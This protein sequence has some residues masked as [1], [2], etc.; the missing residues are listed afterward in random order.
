N[1]PVPDPKLPSGVVTFVLTDI[2][3]STRMLRRLE[4]RY[5]DVLERHI[6]L[7]REVWEEHGGAYVSATGDSCFGAFPDAAAALRA[8]GE[9]HRGLGQE[10][11]STD[12]GLRVRMGIHTGLAS[13]RRDGYVALAVHQ[14]ERVMA[15]AHGGQIL[16]SDVSARNVESLGGF[17]L[18]SAGRYRL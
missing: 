7:L 2:E 15:A 10:Q 14:T 17:K 6:D 11:W 8:C 16:V 9:A 5:D 18:R 4:E 3:A 12:A 1:E 13:P